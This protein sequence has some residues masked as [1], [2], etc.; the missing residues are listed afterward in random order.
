MDRNEML[1]RYDENKASDIY[2][3]GF[4][5]DGLLYTVFTK[6]LRDDC[7]KFEKA[8]EKKGGYNKIRVRLTKKVKAIYI[9]NHK[10]VCWGKIEIMNFNDQYNNGEHF[11]RVAVE[12]LTGRKWVKDSKPFNVTGDF[13]YAGQQVQAKFDDAELTNE[14]ILAGL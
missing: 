8:A 13:E 14:K 7:L 2:L 11:E 9:N 3:L 10:A 12:R 1:H 5:S 4:E 6:E